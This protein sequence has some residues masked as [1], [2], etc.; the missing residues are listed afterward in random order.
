MFGPSGQFFCRFFWLARPMLEGGNEATGNRDPTPPKKL[1]AQAPLDHVGPRPANSCQNFGSPGFF[2]PEFWPPRP[3]LETWE[4]RRPAI[5]DPT[6]PQKKMLQAFAMMMMMMID[7]DDFA[8]LT[9]LAPRA[10][11]KFAWAL[12]LRVTTT[13]SE[14][15][16]PE[17]AL[18]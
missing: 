3:I 18:C 13:G 8:L 16:S 10:H 15:S 6:P 12:E 4:A 2:F 11:L 1:L 9:P 5:G 14:S 17:G 7:D